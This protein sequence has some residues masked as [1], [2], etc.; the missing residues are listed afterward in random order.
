MHFNAKETTIKKNLL[1]VIK[2]VDGDGIILEDIITK[3]EIEVRFLGIDAPEIKRCKKLTN[4]EKELHIPAEFLLQ[5]GYKSLIFIKKKVKIGEICS[6]VQEE[7]NLKDKYGRHLGYL[8]LNNGKVL[9]EIM[10]K[11]GFAKPYNDVYCEMLPKYQQLSL[12]AKSKKKGL[13]KFVNKF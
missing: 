1:K 9:N 6:L 10:V 11:N 13:Y 2:F 8:V 3:K 7:K 5:L 12:Q 4:D